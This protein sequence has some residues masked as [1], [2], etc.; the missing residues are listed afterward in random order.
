MAKKYLFF[1]TETTGVDRFNDRIVQI[2]WILTDEQDNELSA[3]SYII[4]PEGFEI[5]ARVSAIHGITT[6]LAMEEGLSLEE[7][8]TAFVYDW[9]KADA[10]VAHNIGFDLSFVTRE[11]ENAGLS[12][13]DK[14]VQYDTMEASTEYC[15]LPGR[16]HGSGYSPYKSPKLIELYR[17]LFNKDYVD[18]SIRRIHARD[19]QDDLFE[20]INILVRELEP[21]LPWLCRECFWELVKREVITL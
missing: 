11:T 8:M 5:P 12:L 13:T 18:R 15:K 3:E 10:I 17:H 16:Y 19:A 7:V 6:E 4:R 2:S 14:P 20:L 9:E 1:D 21:V